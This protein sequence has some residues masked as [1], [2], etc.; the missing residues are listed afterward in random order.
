MTALR[1]SLVTFVAATAALAALVTTSAKPDAEPQP[2]AGGKVDTE[3]V[4]K[5][6]SKGNLQTA[7]KIRWGTC[8][9]NGLYISSAHFKRR[10]NEPWMQVLGDARA[11]AMI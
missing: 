7:W 3:I 9:G 4:Q 1:L 5:F 2:A 10:P 11:S 6:P 8:V